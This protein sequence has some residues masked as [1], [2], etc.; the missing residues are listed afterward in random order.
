MAH[1]IMEND[2]AVFNRVAAWHRLGTV[3]DSDL[4]PTEALKA[5]GLDWN[6][7]K[8]GFVKAEHPDIGT[9]FSEDY[10]AIV[11][12]DTQEILSVQSDDYQVIQNSE[13]FE[14]AY[15]LSKDVKVESALSLKNGRKIVLLLRGDTFDVA[16]SSGD[17]VTEYMGLINSHDGSIAF[18][19]LPTSVRI[20]C[21]NTLSMAIA[22]ARRGKNMF[23]ITHKGTTMEDKKE[24]MRD[25]LREFKSSGKFFRETV[26]TL[27]NYELTK[28]DIQKFWMDV[29]GMI[30]APIVSNP[31]TD[32]EK[33]NYDNALK[34]VSSWSETFDRERDETKSKASVW[35]AANAVSKFIQHRV[36]ARGRKASIEN[37]AW[38]NLAGLNQ[39]STM[40]V[41][42]HALTLV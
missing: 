1:E 15:E 7:I 20:V 14:M 40:K 26:D 36:A 8:T 30:E 42:R 10:S 41:F 24:A 6:V 33:S 38:D 27:A 31:T 11:R 22:N 25:A 3:V 9:V 12:Q 13:H 18:S 37:R 4:S 23:R 16:G 35:M 34:A 28:T 5:A 2:G 19:A 21:Q 39:D 29:W 32:A 17:T